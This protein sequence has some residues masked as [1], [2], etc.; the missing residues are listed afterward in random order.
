M[1]FPWVSFLKERKKRL[2]DIEYLAIKEFD[3]K[4]R[5]NE[6]N[7]ASGATGDLVTLTANSGKDLYLARA[8]CTIIPNA[9]NDSFTGEIVLKVNGVIFE[10]TKWRRKGS[11]GAGD[12]GQMAHV[13]EFVNV[14][15]KVAA[16]QIIKLEVISNTLSL[17][18]GFLSC[19]E[20][21]TGESP[22]V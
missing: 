21:T 5:E 14:G 7:V 11:T 15:Q 22:A 6:N 17:C 13:Y 18:E 4:L 19:F 16:T 3:G 12:T 2:S 9:G 8:K 10:T 1:V 20:E